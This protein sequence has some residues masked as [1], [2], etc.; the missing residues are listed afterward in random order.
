MRLFYSLGVCVR[1]I[2]GLRSK[3]PMPTVTAMTWIGEP[4]PLSRLPGKF[5]NVN[6]AAMVMIVCN[7]YPWAGVLV[8]APQSEL[9]VYPAGGRRA[10]GMASAAVKAL[11]PP[12]GTLREALTLL[13][14]PDVAKAVGQ[15][16]LNV[17]RYT[18]CHSTVC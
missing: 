6:P 15:Y 18:W 13:A 9:C 7:G 17:S 11:V 16:G 14:T 8:Q 12:V 1:S 3:K 10:H 5:T 2:S 4:A